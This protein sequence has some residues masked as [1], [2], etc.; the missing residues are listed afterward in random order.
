LLAAGASGGTVAPRR[1]LEALLLERRP[2][3]EQVAQVRV[4]VE[5]RTADE[6]AD[7]VLRVLGRRAG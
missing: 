2:L 3:Y 7:E 4:S 6:V 1:R 5:G